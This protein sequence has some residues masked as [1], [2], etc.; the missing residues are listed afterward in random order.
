M[1]QSEEIESRLLRGRQAFSARNY[2]EVVATL[3]N[4]SMALNAEALTLVSEALARLS[5]NPAE[6]EQITKIRICAANLGSVLACERVAE[7]YY[8]DQRRLD[9]AKEYFRKAQALG[10]NLASRR[11]AEHYLNTGSDYE[12]AQCFKVAA[13][14]GNANAMYEYAK[15]IELGLVKPV[16]LEYPSNFFKEFLSKKNARIKDSSEWYLRAATAGAIE[17]V[18]KLMNTPLVTGGKE[19]MLSLSITTDDIEKGCNYGDRF[20]LAVKGYWYLYAN[21]FPGGGAERRDSK[22]IAL[23]LLTRSAKL[24]NVFAMG[25]LG[26]L[27][28]NDFIFPKDSNKAFAWSLIAIKRD[29]NYSPPIERN[30]RLLCDVEAE[31]PLQISDAIKKDPENFVG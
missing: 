17:V 28:D 24:G 20:A 25:T 8:L 5:K 1:S 11:L 31:I 29:E 2:E 4:Q 15:L 23:E 16:Y 19:L 14:H 27:Y 9:D 3:H 30:G 6:W 12:R 22:Q 10:S 13:K 18:G 21:R 7:E 26:L